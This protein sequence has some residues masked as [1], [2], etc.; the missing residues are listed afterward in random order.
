MLINNLDPAFNL[1]PEN[2]PPSHHHHHH[3]QK[4]IIVPYKPPLTL[5]IQEHAPADPYGHGYLITTNCP[6]KADRQT[7]KRHT[8][9]SWCLLNKLTRPLSNTTNNAKHSH[10]L[11][12]TSQIACGDNR[13]AQLV[14]CHL[15]QDRATA[16][17]AKIYDPL[18]YDF[19]DKAD[20][21][22]PVDVAWLAEHDYRREAAAYAELKRCRQDGR[23]TPRYFGS[24]IFDMAHGG[25]PQEEEEK[26]E[27]DDREEK[28]EEGGETRPVHMILLEALDGRTMFSLLE[29]KQHLKLSLRLRLDIFARVLEA[30]TALRFYNVAQDDLAPRNVMLTGLDFDSPHQSV[31]RVVLFD[32]NEAVVLT[33]R[34]CRIVHD[35]MATDRPTMSPRCRFWSDFPYEFGDW[36]YPLFQRK[37][38]FRCWLLS[39]WGDDETFG[40]PPTESEKK[41]RRQDRYEEP[42]PLRDDELDEK[43]VEQ[44]NEELGCDWRRFV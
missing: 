33:H 14:R 28:G 34:K 31:D 19:A 7:L 22:I 44:L 6:A 17:V 37:N 8:K 5:S 4:P 25:G 43:L 23:F 32:F 36:V 40:G 11:H 12:I 39:R 10:Q 15:D 42:P 41:S 24:W 1:P 18:Y 16:Y 21:E 20:R 2:P 29:S 13:G 38:T 27:E 3:H 9:L 26:D 35:K 30:A